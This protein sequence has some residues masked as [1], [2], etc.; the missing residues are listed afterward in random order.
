MTESKR[1]FQQKVD[2]FF[3]A[4]YGDW[5]RIVAKNP[6]KVFF[7]SLTMFT[8]LSTGMFRYNRFENEQIMWTP[9]HN[10]SI[11]GQQRAQEIFTDDSFFIRALYEVKQKD[12][13][14]ILTLNSF[15]EINQFNILLNKTEVDISDHQKMKY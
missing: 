12:Q 1:S 4:I 8:L 2:T 3:S 9:E 6:K 7:L 14:N 5:G 11:E 15:K 13:A 10:E